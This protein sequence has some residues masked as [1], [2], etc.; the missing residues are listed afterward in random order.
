M[1]VYLIS[2]NL[3]HRGRRGSQAADGNGTVE[4]GVCQRKEK[5]KKQ[6][7]THGIWE[8]QSWF[9]RV[10]K[11]RGDVREALTVTERMA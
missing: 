10:S 6:E 8:H 5:H 7:Q 11:C 9:L 1:G 2:L 3:A 4:E